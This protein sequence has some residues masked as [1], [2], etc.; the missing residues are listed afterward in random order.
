[1]RLYGG[2]SSMRRFRPRSKTTTER[3][4]AVRTSAAVDPPGPEPT[5]M[6]SK[7][8]VTL[9]D[10]R[11]GVAPRL[12]VTGE[13]DVLPPDLAL[14]AAV[15][16]RP[17]HALAGVG[18]EHGGEDLVGPEALILF[19]GRHRGEVGPQ[20]LQ[21]VAIHLLEALDGTQPL[22]LRQTERP[23][24]AGSPG[25]FLERG[26]VVERGKA[27][28]SP[29]SAREGTAGPDQRGI[30]GKGTQEAVDIVDD[31]GFACTGLVIGGDQPGARGVDG[32]VLRIGEEAGHE[33]L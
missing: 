19:D 26:E 24:D 16:G 21:P 10:L 32:C 20:C 12:H 14:V 2:S 23:L 3:P 4:A 15:L 31:A 1:M 33:R 17:V 9:A 27:G 7:S 25:Q 6:T 13:V 29:E 8:L 11:I 5:M 18:V 30:A 22:A 28:R